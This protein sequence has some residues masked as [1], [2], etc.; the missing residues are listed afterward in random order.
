MYELVTE[1]WGFW[2]K[3]E[4]VFIAGI[5]SDDFEPEGVAFLTPEDFGL[6]VAV[7]NRAKG[8][9][10]PAH[11]HHP[12]PRALTGT[13]EVLIIKRG[14]LRA[15]LY[16]K[17]SNYLCSVNLNPGDVI[18]LNAGGH[19]FQASDDC[20]FIEVK[21]GPYV[22]GQDKETFPGIGDLNVR[23]AE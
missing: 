3:S 2:I 10:I 23:W 7:M 12:V 19:G 18:I 22:E 9:E 20:T 8:Y 1:K 4:G 21:Q 6:Q 5:V 14:T 17:D 11:F 13:K 16:S 15:D